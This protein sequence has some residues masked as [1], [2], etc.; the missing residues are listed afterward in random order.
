MH[1]TTVSAGTIQS[2]LKGVNSG[3]TTRWQ[4][5]LIRYRKTIDNLVVDITNPYQISTAER[6][7]LA[8][9]I[10]HANMAIYRCQSADN[11]DPDGL[12]A[13]AA[14][15]GLG[16]PDRNLCADEDGLS[17][18]QV[19][20][21]SARQRYIPYTNKPLN[22]HTDGYYHTP[23]RIIRTMLLHCVRPA[24][25]GGTLEA[26]DHEIIYGLL[27]EQHPRLA[28]ALCRPDAMTIPENRPKDGPHRAECS[29]PVF[30][31]NAGVLCMRYTA[32]KQNVIWKHDNQTRE[33][34]AALEEIL[35]RS[36]DLILR[37]RL[38]PGEGLVSANVPHRREA[39]KDSPQAHETRLVY[40]GRYTSAL[41]I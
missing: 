22:W 30:F 6:A 24:R 18:I 23:D 36:G 19:E 16:V 14:Q 40:R 3:A 1:A 11:I 39:F 20:K 41:Q 38:R 31:W 5:R 25:H 15:L 26:M 27:R 37:R 12:T 10:K 17:K 34:V 29:G 35:S 33:G 28:E 32:R 7:A 8:V 21:I 2:Q 13:L 9:R 4:E